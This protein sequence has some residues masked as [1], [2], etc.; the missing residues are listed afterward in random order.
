MFGTLEAMDGWEM[1]FS[2]WDFAY[3]EGANLLVLERVRIWA[4]LCDI[5]WITKNGEHKAE[6]AIFR[7]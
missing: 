5:T 2:F 3:F 7:S 4:V 1:R 6:T